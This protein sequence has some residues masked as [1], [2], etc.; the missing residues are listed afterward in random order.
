MKYGGGERRG[1]SDVVR[2]LAWMLRRLFAEV[3]AEDAIDVV[4]PVPLH[5]RRLRARGFSQ[6]H[7][8]LRVLAANPLPPKRALPLP[9]PRPLPLWNALLRSR[10][11]AEQA[12]LSR[13]ERLRN[14][15]GAFAVTLPGAPRVVGKRVLLLDDVVTTGATASAA[16]RALLDAGTAAVTVLALARAEG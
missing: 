2:S 6:A 1:R 14:V 5:P 12:G 15:A 4:V 7:E 10:E 16:A 8:L 9:P 13:T 3:V 11:T